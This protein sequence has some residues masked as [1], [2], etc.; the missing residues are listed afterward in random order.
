[1]NIRLS[2]VVLFVYACAAPT[3]QHDGRAP[4]LEASLK[5]LDKESDVHFR[6]LRNYAAYS[7]AAAVKDNADE[8][9]EKN[10]DIKKD[11]DHEGRDKDKGKNVS[12]SMSQLI[13]PEL[14]HECTLGYLSD[15]DDED[16]NKD[17]GEKHHAKEKENDE[18]DDKKKNDKR[19]KA[20]QKPT[21]K[22]KKTS[23]PTNKPNSTKRKTTKP[24]KKTN[25]A[26]R[27]TLPPCQVRGTNYHRCDPNKMKSRDHATCRQIDNE[28]CAQQK[29]KMNRRDAS[30]CECIGLKPS[31]AE[32]NVLVDVIGQLRGFI[33]I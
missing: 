15:K 31:S 22:P 9:N 7:L 2:S 13:F 14:S 8:E 21:K 3:E 25:S 27:K 23:K 33:S 17:D 19:E 10:D 28:L 29:R 16:T 12:R 11:N 24:T 5:L 20:T 4:S 26:T 30:Y 1:M 18:D 6:W 32:E